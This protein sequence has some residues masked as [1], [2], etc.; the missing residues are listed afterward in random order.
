MFR[1]PATETAKAIE[2]TARS[3]AAMWTRPHAA[4]DDRPL[5]FGQSGLPAFAFDF[6]VADRLGRRLTQINLADGGHAV[7]TRRAVHRQ[8][9]I[10]RRAQRAPEL[11]E[12]RMNSVA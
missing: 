2:Q 12:R 6:S 4:A 5:R 9:A 11:D 3:T 1:G 10:G 7:R 8:L